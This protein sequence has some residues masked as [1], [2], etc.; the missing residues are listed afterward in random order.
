MFI[1]KNYIVLLLCCLIAACGYKFSGGG[2]MPGAIKS[3]GIA[4]FKNNSSEAGFEN[5]ITNKLSY[6]LIKSQKVKVQTQNAEAILFGI[7]QSVSV[8]SIFVASDNTS[9]EKR[10]TVIAD[11][12]LISA[13]GK[14]LWVLKGISENEA[15]DTD[16]SDKFNE[17]KN[18]NTAF[19]IL[20][21]KLA[22]KIFNR[23]VENF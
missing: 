3:I 12:K 19:E 5:T 18:K 8:K 17:D 9:A 6:E 23:M 14:E 7:I 20:A 15:Y 1:K 4:I 21:E 10:I 2:S 16:A 22:E 11:L 13:A